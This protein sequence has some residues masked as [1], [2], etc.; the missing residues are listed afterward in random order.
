MVF[1]PVEDKVEDTHVQEFVCR[2]LAH[3]IL[4]AAHIMNAKIHAANYHIPQLDRD[5]FI[6]AT[7]DLKI[8]LS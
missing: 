6:F 2:P 3:E 5:R 7:G 4:N 1:Q 8:I